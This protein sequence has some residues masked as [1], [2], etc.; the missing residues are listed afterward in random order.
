ME[1]RGTDCAFA[2]MVKKTS[3]TF[4]K[5]GRVRQKVGD[6]SSLLAGFAL[7]GALPPEVIAGERK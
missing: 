6:F 5:S 3:P 7:A 2:Q 4:S 1:A